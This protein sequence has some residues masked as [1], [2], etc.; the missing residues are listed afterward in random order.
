LPGELSDHSGSGE[1]ID[2]PGLNAFGQNARKINKE[3]QLIDFHLLTTKREKPR[4]FPLCH[5]P[6][7]PHGGAQ[8]PGELSE[9]SVRITA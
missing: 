7:A 4:F 3:N 9:H 2:K 8:L 5:Q 6:D 1:T